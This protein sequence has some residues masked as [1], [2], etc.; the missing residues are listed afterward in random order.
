FPYRV[1]SDDCDDIDVKNPG[2]CWLAAII[3][4]A[5]GVNG[6]CTC[7]VRRVFPWLVTIRLIPSSPTKKEG[8]HQQGSLCS[9]S[10]GGGVL[11]GGDVFVGWPKL[12]GLSKNNLP[13]LP[14]AAA[15]YGYVA[16]GNRSM[17]PD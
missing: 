5:S 8:P 2:S 1:P 3:A 16:V 12:A 14:A 7:Q 11:V 10:S 15:R 13:S 4:A 6:I 17:P 9:V